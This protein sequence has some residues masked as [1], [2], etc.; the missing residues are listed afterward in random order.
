MLA[1]AS[2]YAATLALSATLIGCG[3]DEPADTFTG[4]GASGNT[5]GASAG[6][7]GGDVS[8]GAGG[9]GGA[10]GG[11]GG[12]GGGTG[13]GGGEGGSGPA[14][15][16]RL[17]VIHLSPD[18][19]GVDYCLSSDGGNNWNG[20]LLEASG[21]ANGIA[22]GEATDYTDVGAAIHVVALVDDDDGDC[23]GGILPDL[24]LTVERD[25]DYTIV[26]GGMV[27][28]ALGDG[29]LEAF[30]YQDDNTAPAA[31]KAHLRFIHMSPDAG[32]LEAGLGQGGG[33]QAIWTGVTFGET[34]VNGGAT[35]HETDPLVDATFT[36][37]APS[38]VLPSN[39]AVLQELDAAAGS[40]TTLF[41]VGNDDDNP[42]DAQFL[43]CEDGGTGSGCVLAP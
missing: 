31:D 38:I 2:R 18:A 42:E 23:E 1:R 34:G 9:Q 7:M 12:Q 16:G 40:I 43:I 39:F 13:G 33:F 17:R 41:A 27:N 19:S 26:V 21:D 25:A 6:G 15:S 3:D 29:S 4:S 37:R 10:A 28:P 14:P 36:A 32:T 11:S 35:Y 20:P 8:G 24:T 5:G 30:T 22:Y